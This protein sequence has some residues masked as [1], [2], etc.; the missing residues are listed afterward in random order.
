MEDADRPRARH[1]SLPVSAPTP[2]GSTAED[3]LRR[4][5]TGH[6]AQ[7]W[8]LHQALWWTL[9]LQCLPGVDRP[10]LRFLATHTF[11]GFFYTL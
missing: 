9:V 1:S 3:R 6:V 11:W 10:Y 5:T 4:Q 8:P 2:L 7:H